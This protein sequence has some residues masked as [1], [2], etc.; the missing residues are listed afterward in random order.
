MR[1][2]GYTKVSTSSQD[3][4]CSLMRCSRSGVQK[5]D[6]FADV[7]SGSRTAVERPE[8][9]RRQARDRKGRTTELAA[10][11]A[12]WSRA[13]LYR[14]PGPEGDSR[15]ERELP[16]LEKRSMEARI[17][18]RSSSA[19]SSAIGLGPYRGAGRWLTCLSKSVPARPD[20]EPRR[21]TSPPE[22]EI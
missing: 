9:D 19:D 13:T 4:N 10:H 22:G 2:L 21:G 6:V 11:L 14:R 5:R 12:N 20:R 7:T 16:R 8:G 18:G 15:S 1:H 3:A 17:D